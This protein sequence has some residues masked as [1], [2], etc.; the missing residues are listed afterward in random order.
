VLSQLL[1]EMDGVEELKGVLI[2]A[3]TN[4]KDMLDPALLRPGRF[5]LQLEV[6][7]PDEKARAAI[8]RVH[9]RGKPVADDV[10]PDRLAKKSEGLTGADIE[11][12]CRRAGLDAVRRFLTAHPGGGD[13]AGLRILAEDLSRAIDELRA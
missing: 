13:P 6:P 3:A 1:T 9:L 2:V 11:L 5:D 7:A 10:H 8:F 12:A 4:R